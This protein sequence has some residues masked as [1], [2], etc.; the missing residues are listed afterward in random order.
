MLEYGMYYKPYALQYIFS[1][2][3]EHQGMMT[4]L[5]ILN[6]EHARSDDVLL[7]LQVN[8]EAYTITGGR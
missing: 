4:S 6:E 8:S 1:S 3:W 7:I 2:T 5:I